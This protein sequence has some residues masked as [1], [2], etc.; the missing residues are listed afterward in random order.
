MRATIVIMYLLLQFIYTRC[1]SYYVPAT[2]VH[3][4]ALL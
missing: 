2:V 3:I 4:C 1:C